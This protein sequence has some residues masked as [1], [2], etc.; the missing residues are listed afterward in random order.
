MSNFSFLHVRQNFD[1]VAAGFDAHDFLYNKI[2]QRQIKRLDVISIEPK[3]ILDCGCGTGQGTQLLFK[4]FK[5]AEIVSIDLSKNMLQQSKAKK[6]WR[7]NNL[8]AQ[9]NTELLPFKN[10]S[11]DFVYSNLMLHWCND[12]NKVF[13]EWQRVLKPNGLLMFTVFGPDTL[14]ELRIAMQ[15]IMPEQALHSFVDIHDLGDALIKNRMVDPVMDVDNIKMEYNSAEDF[16]KD[17]HALGGRNLNSARVK[18]LKTSRFSDK[19]KHELNALKNE[20]LTISY[21][22]IYGHAW[23]SDLSQQSIKNNVVN[24]PI[25][26]LKIKK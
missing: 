21:E 8:F 17:L 3:R 11:F 25:Q 19:L 6:R 22:I 13:S 15:K 9:A 14:Q 1:R 26:S 24:I 12:L 16:L 4:R 10:N 7:Q 2:N 23:A 20:K 18:T 5:K